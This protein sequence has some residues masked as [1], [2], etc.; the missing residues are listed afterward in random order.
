MVPN[1]LPSLLLYAL[2]FSLWGWMKSGVCKT[3]VFTRDELVARIL[4]AAARVK[5]P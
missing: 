2:D 3:K 4:E 5:K 1:L